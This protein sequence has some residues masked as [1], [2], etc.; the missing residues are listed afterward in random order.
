MRKIITPKKRE[1]D[2]TCAT[3]VRNQIAVL[4]RVN[5]SHVHPVLKVVDSTAGELQLEQTNFYH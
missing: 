2:L 1:K 4:V 5:T 3:A